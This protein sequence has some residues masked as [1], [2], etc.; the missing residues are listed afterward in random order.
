M[1]PIVPP[2]ELARLAQ[3]LHHPPRHYGLALKADASEI[4]TDLLPYLWEFGGRLLDE[5]GRPDFAHPANIKA[6]EYY[7]ALKHWCPADTE[8]YGNEAIAHTL[9]TGEA[10]LVANWG[11]QTAPIFLD[12][13]NPW[14]DRYRTALFPHPWNATWGIAIAANQ[15]EIDQ[16]KTLEALMRLLSPAS[17]REIT[18]VAGSPIRN[19]SYDP[20]SLERYP[21]LAAQR[22]MLR[23][24]R[25]LPADPNLGQCLGS[26]YE[27]VHHA[28]SGK[29][30]AKEALETVQNRCG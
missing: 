10:A 1:S 29:V 30:S 28:F 9:R 3:K 24:A 15:P 18:R 11:G 5:E 20:A 26:L 17:D 27:A 7:C 22:E 12:P 25:P 19:S 2:E 23:R 4:L 13:D 6:L 21:W 14:R 8:H 16:I